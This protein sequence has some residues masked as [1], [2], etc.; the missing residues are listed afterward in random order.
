MSLSLTNLE[1]RLAAP[2]GAALRNALAERAARLEQSLRARM[3]GGLPR[4]DFS[5][6]QAAAEAAAAAREILASWPANDTAPPAPR[7]PA[8]PF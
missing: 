7:E 8:R 2:G 4:Q 1:T 6:W 5:A 3:A